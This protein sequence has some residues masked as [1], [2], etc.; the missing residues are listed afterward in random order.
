MSRGKGSYVLLQKWNYHLHIV[1]D[2]EY[3]SV[4]FVNYNVWSLPINC[5][6]LHQRHV[7]WK[8]HENK[9]L[10]IINIIQKDCIYKLSY[11]LVVVTK[12]ICVGSSRHMDFT[13][14]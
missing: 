10:V 7:V 12:K 6:S 2:M 11:N 14:L 3:F 1:K 5:N 13:S 4:Q 8:T 9:I